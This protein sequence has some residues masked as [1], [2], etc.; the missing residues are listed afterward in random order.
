MLGARGRV[1][2]AALAFAAA[3]LLAQGHRVDVA[4]APWAAT[5]DLPALSWLCHTVLP[6]RPEWPDDLP[7]S[8][9]FVVH[10]DGDGLTLAPNEVSLPEGSLAAGSFDLGDG[11]HVLCVCMMDG[12]EDWYVPLDAGVPLRFA[13]ALHALRATDV[14]RAHTIDLAV[15]VGHFLGATATGDTLRETIQLGAALCGEV[16]WQAWRNDQYVRVR[17]QIGR[18][19]V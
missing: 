12:T 19:H 16:T 18:A 2:A 8:S 14:D 15:A 4:F 6:Q 10:L 13:R 3:P 11:V 17:G 5:S 9:S 1:G 7:P